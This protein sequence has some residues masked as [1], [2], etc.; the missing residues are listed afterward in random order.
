[1]TGGAREITL[2]EVAEKASFLTTV[3]YNLYVFACHVLVELVS[4]H[5]MFGDGEECFEDDQLNRHWP[6]RQ[7]AGQIDEL[8]RHESA[9]AYP[10][11]FPTNL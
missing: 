1:M 9:Q 6:C 5:L 10:N 11:S 2:R 7:D 8:F 4:L 3:V